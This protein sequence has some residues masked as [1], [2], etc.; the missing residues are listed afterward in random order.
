MLTQTKNFFF[1]GLVTA[2][3]I[4]AYYLPGLLGESRY[5][6]CK[7]NTAYAN[8][9]FGLNIMLPMAI[10]S[11]ILLLVVSTKRYILRTSV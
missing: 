5:P 7:M 11:L 4:L 3:E 6:D 10:S 8:L 9:M 2:C 1:Y